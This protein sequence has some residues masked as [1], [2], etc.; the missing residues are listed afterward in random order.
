MKLRYKEMAES[1]LTTLW[2]IRQHNE[3]E[4]HG[5]SGYNHGRA[6][7]PL[8]LLSQYFAGIS[9]DSNHFNTYT[10]KPMLAGLHFIKT[11]VPL[12]SGLLHFYIWQNR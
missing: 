8:V 10:I 3:G 2:E 11:T 5:N 1:P 6:G 4:V 9:P 12:T 7:G